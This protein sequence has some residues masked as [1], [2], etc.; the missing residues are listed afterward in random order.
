MRTYIVGGCNAQ[1]H[2]QT[3]LV[4]TR[5]RAFLC[6]SHCLVYSF[7]GSCLWTTTQQPDPWFHQMRLPVRKGALAASF[8]VQ[9]FGCA[10]ARSTHISEGPHKIQFEQIQGDHI[11]WFTC[12]LSLI[13]WISDTRSQ[14]YI[15][16]QSLVKCLD[17]RGVASGTYT[18]CSQARLC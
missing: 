8:G 2:H 17:H 9:A 16:L 18:V 3:A 5:R 10:C 7:G 14:G 11:S 6:A 13:D 15:N 1:S 4:V 12:H